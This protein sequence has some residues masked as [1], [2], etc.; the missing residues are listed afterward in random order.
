MDV[1]DVIAVIFASAVLVW[2]IAAG[3]ALVVTVA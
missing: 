1:D 2:M 3:V